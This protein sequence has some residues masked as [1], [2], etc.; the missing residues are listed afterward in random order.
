MKQLYT[1]LVAV[2]ATVQ[3]SYGQWTGTTNIIN[4]NSGNV[5]IGVTVPY[6][7]LAVDLN[8][9]S[10]GFPVA[11][12]FNSQLSSGQNTFF[13]LGQSITSNNSFV[14]QYDHSTA[15]TNRRLQIYAYEAGGN[16]FTL[17]ANG[18]VGIGTTAPVAKLHIAGNVASSAWGV[19]SPQFLIGGVA[20]I[21]NSTAAGGTVAGMTATDASFN[22]STITALNATIGSPVT[23][24]NASTIYVVG[25]AVA[26]VN[27]AITNPYSLYIANGNTFLGPG[28]TQASRLQLGSS[29]FST[30]TIGTTGNILSVLANTIN[31]TGTAASGTVSTVAANSIAAPTLAATNAGVTY[32]NAATMYIAG[33]PTAGPNVTI[34]NPTA[35]YVAAGNSYFGGN[36]GIGTMQPDAKLTV[37]GTIHST[38][39]KVTAAVPA[40]DY[41]FEPAYKLPKLTELKTYLD[42]NHHLPEIPSAAD[43]EKNGINLSEMNLKLLKKVEELTLY[44]IQI[45]EE[46]QK[47][48]QA[49]QKQIDELKDRLKSIAKP[50]IY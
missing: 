19:N 47:T 22:Q 25:P 33:A 34:T 9:S 1:T 37:N 45:K 38:E 28:L 26:G 40:P 29:N 42:D 10:T 36:I 8:T 16:Q 2:I 24:A 21:D 18:N 14:F 12:F 13:T 49:Q 32:S 50:N 35:L 3:L 17:L 41:V 48:T 39:V 23:Y 5:G 15:A 4:T 43:M 27:T 20:L 11:H 6:A 44:V 30:S 7:K 46:Q 31:D